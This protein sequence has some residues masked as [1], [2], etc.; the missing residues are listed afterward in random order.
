M[1]VT[2]LMKCSP[3]CLPEDCISRANLRPRIGKAA[4]DYQKYVRSNTQRK[5]TTQPAQRTDASAHE[6]SSPRPLWY[7][8][9]ATHPITATI[10][11]H[12]IIP[13][14]PPISCT[15]SNN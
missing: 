12:P 3:V 7:V 5:A 14:P 8:R 4:L 1:V 6:F 15:C 13:T 2:L 11:S 9:H 10:P